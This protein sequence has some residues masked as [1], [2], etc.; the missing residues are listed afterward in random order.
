MYTKEEVDAKLEAVTGD[1]GEGVTVESYV[2]EAKTEAV[3]DSK[4]YTDSV[5]KLNIV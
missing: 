1:M 4:D 5:L 3:S 2:S